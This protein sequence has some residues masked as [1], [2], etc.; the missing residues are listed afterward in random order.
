MELQ[1]SLELPSQLTPT[2]E[3]I[4]GCTKVR[5]NKHKGHWGTAGTMS[6]F[7]HTKES[8]ASSPTARMPVLFQ[9][10]TCHRAWHFSLA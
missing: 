3:V 7:L 8:N 6:V 5:G 4:S 1:N 2:R 10:E 9:E